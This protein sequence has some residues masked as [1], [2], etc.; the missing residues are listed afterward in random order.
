MYVTALAFAKFKN[1]RVIITRDSRHQAHQSH[2]CLVRWGAGAFIHTRARGPI[3]AFALGI[4]HSGMSAGSPNKVAKRGS[5]GA[6]GG[7]DEDAMGAWV[8][9]RKGEAGGGAPG[10]EAPPD[11]LLGQGGSQEQRPE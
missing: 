1:I 7:G 11:V 9:T 2:T 5:G 8:S 6:G 10:D 3:I 4:S